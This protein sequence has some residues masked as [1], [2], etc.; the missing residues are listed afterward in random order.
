MLLHDLKISDAELNEIVLANRIFRSLDLTLIAKKFESQILKNEYRILPILPINGRI[1]AF[2]DIYRISINRYIRED[3]KNGRLHYI[4]NLKYPPQIKS[5]ELYYNRCNY[6]G[7]SIFYG[8]FGTLYSMVETRPQRGDLITVSQ[9]KLNIEEKLCYVP[10]FQDKGI[11]KYTNLFNEQWLEYEKVLNKLDNKTKYGIEQIYS[12]ITFFFNRKVKDKIEYIF[13]AY[14]AEHFFNIPYIHKIEAIL[15]PSVPNQYMSCNL[16]I[17][18]DVFD[19]KVKFIKAEEQIVIVDPSL[20]GGWGS[21]QIAVVTD[22]VND[23]LI[24]EDRMYSKTLDN[25]TA[26]FNLTFN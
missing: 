13:S 7:Q 16:A 15:Y 20:S 14:F 10:I 17:L 2:N 6:K 26:Q 22:V 11:L 1:G 5:H 24:W 3:R 21:E 9:W 12:L 19:Q 8:G 25:Y 23:K 4:Q 18:P